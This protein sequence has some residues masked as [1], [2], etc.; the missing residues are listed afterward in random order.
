MKHIARFFFSPYGRTGRRLY[1][2]FFILPLTT[3]VFGITLYQ[4]MSGQILPLEVLLVLSPI[5]LWSQG[6]VIARRLQDIGAPGGLALVFILTPLAL[7]LL[8]FGELGGKV[9][10]ALFLA[11]LA[12]GAIPGQKGANRFGPDPWAR[13]AT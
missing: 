5:L 8:G 6:A 10:F 1:W 12:L 2:L 13:D 4:R 11:T 9:Q 3:L 7:L